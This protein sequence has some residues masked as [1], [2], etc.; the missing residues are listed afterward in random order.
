MSVAH[1][2]VKIVEDNRTRLFRPGGEIRAR[3]PVNEIALEHRGIASDD[4]APLIAG[5]GLVIGQG[6][7]Q[8]IDDAVDLLTDG[9]IAMACGDCSEIKSVEFI[10]YLN[11]STPIHGPLRS[12]AM[13]RPLF[14]NTKTA[15]SGGCSSESCVEVPIR[16]DPFFRPL[17][18]GVMRPVTDRP[19]R[20]C[21]C[22]SPLTA[23]YSL[24]HFDA[25]A[26]LQDA[27]RTGFMCRLQPSRG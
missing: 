17:D 14:Q 2:F 5:Q 15:R 18:P 22:P 19:A 7:N 3:H 11:S 6:S 16:L 21:R 10:S 27:L 23:R 13:L 25:R 9:S 8:L 24:A 1:F 20:I 26:S 4:A 12:G